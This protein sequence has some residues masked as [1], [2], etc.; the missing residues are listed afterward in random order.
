MLLERSLVSC[1]PASALDAVSSRP[2]LRPQRLSRFEGEKP[3]GG[4]YD[5]SARLLLATPRLTQNA[6][7]VEK[8]NCKTLKAATSLD[9]PINEVRDI[10]RQARVDVSKG[11]QVTGAVAQ[12][13]SVAVASSCSC[14]WAFRHVSVPLKSASKTRIADEEKWQVTV[15]GEQVVGRP[16]FPD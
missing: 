8:T 2:G 7:K 14:W 11:K 9:T 4:A 10:L 15:Q 16:F 1:E 3:G 12:R 6:Q 13:S 5:L